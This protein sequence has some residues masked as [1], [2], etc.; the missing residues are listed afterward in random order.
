MCPVYDAIKTQWKVNVLLL[1]AL[2]RQS[3]LLLCPFCGG[4]NEMCVDSGGSGEFIPV[5][6]NR[7]ELCL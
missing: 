2:V 3:D 7:C 5:K 1:Q 6:M 4:G